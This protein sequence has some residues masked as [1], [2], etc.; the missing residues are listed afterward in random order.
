MIIADEAPGI[1][2]GLWDAIAGTMA[3]GKVHIVMAGNPTTASGAFFDAFTRE[4][5]LW[6]C[7][8]I[9]ALQSL[10]LRGISLEGL[11]ELNPAPGGPLDQNPIPYLVTKRWVYEQYLLWWHGDEASSPRWM[12]RV[13]AEFPQQAQNALIKLAWLERA[14]TRAR[15]SPVQ[16]T[17]GALVAGV[18]VGGGE[19][20]TA[21]Y[22]CESLPERHKI[23]KVGG[24]RGEDTRGQVARFL[25]P[26]RRRLSVV[27]VNAIG[28]GH[29]FGLHLRDLELP[30]ELVNVALPCEARPEL[31]ENDPARRFTNY[32]AQLYQNLADAFERNQIDGLT[33]DAT[34]G[35]LASMLYE[36]DSRGRIRIEPKEKA[37][38]RGVPSPDRA[39]ALMLAYVPAVGGPCSVYDWTCPDSVDGIGLV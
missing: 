17:G 23:I 4:R 6:N 5:A 10:N 37:R 2:A 11:L 13:R 28:I 14:R 20:E 30:V 7:I 39:E 26:Y 34:V 1:V 15:E 38:Q 31:G 27:R 19:A 21:V 18:N 32:K 9:D 16:D 22:L 25:E 24:W 33:D 36:I 35:Q 29:N 3:G 8:S 12:G